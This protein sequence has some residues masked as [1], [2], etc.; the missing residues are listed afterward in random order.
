MVPRG[1]RDFAQ[2]YTRFGII[3][4]S[5]DFSIQIHAISSNESY[6]FQKDLRKQHSGSYK[7]FE[8]A[9]R[10]ITTEIQERANF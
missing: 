4:W 9:F 6:L 5:P 1:M 7:E 8:W 2:S 3:I 10:V